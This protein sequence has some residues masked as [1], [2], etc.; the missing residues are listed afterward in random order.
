MSG[1]LTGPS[2]SRAVLKPAGRDQT[3]PP[4]SRQHSRLRGHLRLPWARVA[5][6]A[7]SRWTWAASRQR[8]G[9]HRRHHQEHEMTQA[10]L[11]PPSCR[12]PRAT[13][14]RGHDSSGLGRTSGLVLRSRRSFTTRADLSPLQHDFP[15]PGR[16]TARRNGKNPV[17]WVIRRFS[18][19]CERF[20]RCHRL[21]Q[22]PRTPSPGQDRPTPDPKPA[23]NPNSAAPYPAADP[24]TSQIS[25]WITVSRTAKRP[26]KPAA[27]GRP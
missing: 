26:A 3:P 19:P 23:P 21:A 9:S 22:R 8:L 15:G 13:A 18:Q 6:L 17:L 12:R 25:R 10:L 5:P 14:Q 24:I 2:G 4:P 11:L 27:E 7:S 1:C 16:G 20:T